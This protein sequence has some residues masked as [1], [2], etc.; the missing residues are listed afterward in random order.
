MVD[1]KNKRCLH[2]GCAKW[3]S[4][5][6][7]GSNKVEFCSGHKRDGMVDLKHKRCLHHGCTKGPSYGVDG[8]NKKEFCSGHK[9][10]GMVNLRSKRCLHQGC[11][12]MPSYGVDG[13][14]TAELCARHAT[15]GMT[16]T[17][18]SRPSS[19]SQGSTEVG[20]GRGGPI[21]STAATRRAGVGEKRKVDVLCSQPPSTCRSS[22]A[23]AQHTGRRSVR[24]GTIPS[25]AVPVK[26]EEAAGATA[27]VSVVASSP[28][29]FAGRKTGAALGQASSSDSEDRVKA[30]VAVS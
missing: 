12:T 23:R 16:P 30:E 24:A 8:S 17:R 14:N 11:L 22:G 15:A 13:S 9:R 4:F 27:A 7:D 28:F 1:L 20:R 18:S 6:V 21:A 19:E 3:P 26:E 25:L 29:V 5:G 10:D 2:H